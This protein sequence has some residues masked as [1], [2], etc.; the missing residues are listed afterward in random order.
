MATIRYK[1]DACLR[2]VE[3]LEN[4]T[5]LTTLSNCII[6]ENCRGSLFKIRRNNRSRVRF[7][8]EDIDLNNNLMNRKER[9]VFFPFSKDIPS[10]RWVVRHNLGSFPA[11]SVFIETDDGIN[12]REANKSEYTRRDID[13]NTL[14]VVFNANQTGKVHA[15]S[16]SIS[17]Q[18]I[19][20]STLVEN[21]INISPNGTLSIAVLSKA[22]GE[23]SIDPQNPIDV[24]F[25]VSLK[26]PNEEEIFCVEEFE[27]GL[28]SPW[29][30]YQ[31]MSLRKRRNYIVKTVNLLDLKV[32]QERYN[33]LTEI[34]EL[35]E[36]K[37]N[38]ISYNGSVF[39]PIRSKNALILLSSPP[40]TKSDKILDKIIDLGERNVETSERKYIFSNGKLFAVEDDILFKVDNSFG[41]A[42]TPT[43]TPSISESVTSTPT[44]TPSISE[45]VTSTPTPTPSISESTTPTPTPSISESVTSTPTPTPS[46]S[47]S[48]T[49]T[50]T[51]SISDSTTPT[52]T[53][54]VSES[55]T[56]TPTPSVSESVISGTWTP[57]E[58]AG[59]IW[60]D[61]T[62]PDY[63]TD[64]GTNLTQLKDVNG[65]SFTFGAPSG[66]ALVDDSTVGDVAEFS[67]GT[68]MVGNFNNGADVGAENGS[69]YDWAVFVPNNATNTGSIWSNAAI[70]G[71]NGS[72]WHDLMMRDTGSGPHCVAYHW[73]GSAEFTE[74]P[75]PLF[76]WVM[77]GQENSAGSIR[78]RLNGG[79]ETSNA[80]GNQNGSQTADLG[81]SGFGASGF[82]G[83]IAMRG[84]LPDAPS[85]PDR[86]KIEGWALH[87]LNLENLLPASHPYKNAPP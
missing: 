47:E 27:S 3:L 31:A 17:D 24:R 35:T 8:E 42:P 6:T 13:K 64:D 75:A 77:A 18:D 41:I 56:P 11:I 57:A 28:R 7:G 78:L 2:E 81:S 68:R 22:F 63:R 36:F 23:S 50:P 16:R 14:E 44:P 74:Q 76:Q 62:E 67:G 54:S 9:K 21:T 82:S 70:S 25:D 20:Q 34:P 85:E 5:G 38:S 86:Q 49:P 80:A 46:V 58:I 52:P 69:Y 40:Y 26:E 30:D 19:P 43:P 83:R 60:F 87:K 29:S 59:A 39:S 72:G 15:I 55:A 65:G 71:D 48:V 45:S 10:K 84:Y 1:C 53:P 4:K 79:S 61:T 37:F 33:S 66:V 32:I 73:D 12:I 51:P